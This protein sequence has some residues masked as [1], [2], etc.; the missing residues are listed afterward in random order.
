M[1]SLSR[2]PP[3]AR[4]SRRR[5]PPC[6][7]GALHLAA[8]TGKLA[9]CRYLVEELR[10]DANAIYDQATAT[11]VP[12]LKRT[13]IGNGGET[14]LAYAVNGANV[15]TVRYLLDHGAHPEK[16]D[17]KGFTPLHFAAEE[18]WVV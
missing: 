2:V 16:A 1:A 14:P 6:G 8:G 13:F 11:S 10:V 9:V 12:I 15:A 5:P 7:A 18:D 17:N 3:P 4:G